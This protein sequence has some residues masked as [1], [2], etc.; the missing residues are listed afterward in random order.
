M[1][2]HGLN[3][4]KDYTMFTLRATIEDVT[5]A[6]ISQDGHEFYTTIL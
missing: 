4:T 1:P 2:Q 3:L 6:A 5:I